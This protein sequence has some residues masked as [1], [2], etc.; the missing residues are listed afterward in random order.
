VT[1]KI[2]FHDP[3]YLGRYRGVYEQ[4]RQVAALGGKVV[5]PGRAREHSFCCGLVV[6]WRFSVKRKAIASA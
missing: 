6:D 2:V 3:C 1:D 5:D 4:P